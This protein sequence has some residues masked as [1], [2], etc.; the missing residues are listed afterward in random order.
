MYTPVELVFIAKP[1]FHTIKYT[2]NL[3]ITYR[4]EEYFEEFEVILTDHHK[5]PDPTLHFVVARFS[6]F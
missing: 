2:C 3:R 1:F 5:H 4:I 6:W